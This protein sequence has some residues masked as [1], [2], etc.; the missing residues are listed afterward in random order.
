[1]QEPLEYDEEAFYTGIMSGTPDDFSDDPYRF[2]A[3]AIEA[4]QDSLGPMNR[5]AAMRGQWATRGRAQQGEMS[6]P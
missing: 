1:M 6:A 4:N 5:R 2:N 3:R